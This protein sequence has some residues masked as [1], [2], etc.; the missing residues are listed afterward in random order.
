MNINYEKN[1]I[2][3]VVVGKV[4]STHLD[5]TSFTVNWMVQII[6]HSIHITLHIVGLNLE[7]IVRGTPGSARVKTRFD[8]QKPHP[9]PQFF[10]K[11]PQKISKYSVLHRLK[12][13]EVK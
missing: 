2:I 6:I 7:G 8:H 3:Y 9:N 12:E 13:K 1:D 5:Q 11:F 4:R 10:L